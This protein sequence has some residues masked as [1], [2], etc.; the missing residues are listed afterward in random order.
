LTRNTRYQGAILH[1]DAL[2]LIQHQHHQTGRT[3]WVLPGGGMEAGETEEQ[4]VVREIREE[5]NLNVEVQ[6]L[7][8][9]EPGP[10]DGLYQWRKTYLCKVINGTPEPGYEPEEEAAAVYSI[11]DVHWFDLRDEH[12]WGE[13]ISQDPITYPQLKR[14]KIELG[15]K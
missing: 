15:Y 10:P 12:S 4:C 5:T 6:R 1:N 14:L 3:Y 9:V 11:T 2:L 7:I 13:Q 8:L